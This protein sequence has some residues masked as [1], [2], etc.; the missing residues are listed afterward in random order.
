M[1]EEGT[2]M[3]CPKCPGTLEERTYGRKITVHRCSECGGLWC[4]PEPLL[5]MKREWMSEAVLDSGDP[6]LGKALDQIEDIKCPED[7]TL[8]A[9]TA[10]ERQTHIWYESCPTCDGMFFDAG[11]FTDLK[12]DTLMDRVRDFVKG[13]RGAKSS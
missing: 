2:T 7:G 6:K 11:E 3:Q 10:D 9:K 13:R 4:K 1:T 5:E 8:M 12:Y